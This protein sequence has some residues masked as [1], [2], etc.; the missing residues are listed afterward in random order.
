RL[1]YVCCCCCCCCCRFKTSPF[2][3]HP[4][5]L[6]PIYDQTYRRYEARGP[7]RALRFWPITRE[8][9]RLVLVRRWFLA[10]LAAAWLPF[11]VQ[12]IRF[13]VVTRFPEANRIL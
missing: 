8:A 4:A 13:Y 5:R 7:L 9:L 3:S 6:M 11:V 12:V 2:S 10:L 1:R